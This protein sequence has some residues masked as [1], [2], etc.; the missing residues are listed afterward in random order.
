MVGAYILRQ[1]DVQIDRTKT[2]TIAIASYAIDSHHISRWM[3][4]AVACGSRADSG[5]G[6]PRPPDGPSRIEA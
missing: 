6:G 5:M 1:R 3:D 2:D 4:G